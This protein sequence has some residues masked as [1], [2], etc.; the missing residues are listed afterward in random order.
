ML[1][2]PG[3]AWL[4]EVEVAVAA[5]GLVLE[6]DVVDEAFLLEIR[7]EGGAWRAGHEA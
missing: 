6:V 5:R 7:R 1:A 3:R 2:D 4:P